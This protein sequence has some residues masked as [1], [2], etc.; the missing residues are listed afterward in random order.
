MSEKQWEEKHHLAVL[1][2]GELLQRIDVI[3]P[4]TPAFLE[5]LPQGDEDD[6]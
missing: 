2:L 5:D 3:G 6:A 4:A 1:S